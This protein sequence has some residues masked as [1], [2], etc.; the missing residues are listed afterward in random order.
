MNSILL[1]FLTLLGFNTVNEPAR[2]YKK[3]TF[4]ERVNYWVYK[5]QYELLLI[6]TILSMVIFALVLF[7]VFAPVESGVYYNHIHEV[8]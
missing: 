8:I 5:H 1:I 3:Y 4:R 7:L 2:L 6:I